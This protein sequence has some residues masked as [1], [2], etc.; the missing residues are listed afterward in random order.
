MQTAAEVRF[1]PASDQ[2]LLIYFDEQITPE[3]HHAVLKLLHLLESEPVSG[4]R[5][6]HPAYCSLL[7]K[8]DSLRYS[9]GEIETILRRYLERSKDTVNP[10]TRKIEIPVSYGGQFGPDLDEIASLHGLTSAQAIELHSSV[11]YVVRF[12]G[13][14]PGF[15]Y[16][17]G[18]PD[19]LATSRLATPRRSVPAGSLGIAG[20]QTG[21]YPFSTPGGWRLIGR[22]QLSMFQVERPQ[23]SLLTIGDQVRFKPISEA[24]FRSSRHP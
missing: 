20:K 6:L 8:F 10:D 23:M 21:I 18:L 17:A 1:Q 14:A 5:N 7:V 11:T 4:V 2:S 24:E 9:H 12:L 13:F 22:T 16:L 3:A 15:A 19:S